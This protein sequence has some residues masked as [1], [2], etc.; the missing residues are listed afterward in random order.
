M[1]KSLLFPPLSSDLKLLSPTTLIGK[2]HIKKKKKKQIK[3]KT[4]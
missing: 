4:E 1:R 3:E 2:K